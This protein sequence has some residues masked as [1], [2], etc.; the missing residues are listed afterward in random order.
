MPPPTASL[1]VPND[2]SSSNSK[3]QDSCVSERVRRLVLLLLDVLLLDV[4]LLTLRPE[5][6]E[7]A[8]SLE[9]RLALS[10][11]WVCVP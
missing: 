2:D 1:A 10:C 6:C 3:K 7:V 11:G 8:L 4:L 9:P 5:V